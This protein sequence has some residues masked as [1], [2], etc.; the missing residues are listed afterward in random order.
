MPRR[1][2]TPFTIYSDVTGLHTPDSTYADSPIASIE[3]DL[4]SDY[5]TET[6]DE[7]RSY[8]YASPRRISELTSASISSIPDSSVQSDD[9]ED[10]YAIRYPPSKERPLFRNASSVRRMQ[11]NSPEPSILGGHHGSPRGSS[12]GRSFRGGTPNSLRVPRAAHI[13][14]SPKPRTR[15]RQEEKDR[16]TYPLVLLHAT[17]LPVTLPWSVQS[18]REILPEK[19]VANVEK[20]R[21]KINEFDLLEER[22]LEALELKK[23]RLTK[24]GHFV[25]RESGSEEG[26]DGGEGED[27]DADTLL[28]STGDG[29]EERCAT[30]RRVV[31][32]SK[33]GLGTEEGRWEIKVYAANGLMRAG[34]WGAAWSDMERVDVEILPWIPDE[35]RK[36]LDAA[37]A[38]ELAALQPQGQQRNQ[39]HREQAQNLDVQM[40]EIEA[41]EPTAE[42][43]AQ[44]MI[45]APSSL[46]PPLIS[47]LRALDRP[48]TRDKI[49]QMP[50]STPAA[51]L[52]Q[53]NIVIAMLAILLLFL[54]VN[55]KPQT[56]LGQLVPNGPVP[57][58][59]LEQIP[60]LEHLEQT[61][62]NNSTPVV[63]ATS[64]SGSEIN[65]LVQ[66][67][68]VPDPAVGA[69]S[70][71]GRASTSTL[72][73][74]EDLPCQTP[75]S[76]FSPLQQRVS[77]SA[78]AQETIATETPV[79][80][81]EAAHQPS[82]E[83]NFADMPPASG[84]P[85]K[86]SATS[87]PVEP[88][89]VL[90]EPD[91]LLVGEGEQP[92]AASTGPDTKGISSPS[93]SVGAALMWELNTDG[94]LFT[95]QQP[96]EQHT[97]VDLAMRAGNVLG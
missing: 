94:A 91:Q 54:S 19:L 88:A 20:L 4:T 78:T 83:G 8:T 23:E 7:A 70:S 58:T 86:Q 76:F 84:E 52:P 64:V 6:D 92:V 15:E 45:C 69:P 51:D 85:T 40:L 44:A 1:S 50:H 27:S 14:T 47:Q 79:T 87:D 59:M 80:E 25:G 43:H 9:A 93:D 77:E 41:V 56:P 16:S 81:P 48:R 46:P 30:C 57:P 67:G 35:L 95:E 37:Q 82:G 74:A 18:M 60:P 96:E 5:M 89:I 55:S 42:R 29:D 63:A 11:L 24:C 73:E 49:T 21:T 32:E 22:L 36:K 10:G 34:A 38:E 66:S 65:L 26:E 90:A 61:I 3:N 68:E 13:R 17:L 2:K 31:K 97:D 12:T 28:G 71:T 72:P 53:A 39:Q 62:F 75:S 33:R